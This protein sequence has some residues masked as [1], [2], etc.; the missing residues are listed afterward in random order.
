MF[1]IIYETTNLVNGKLYR[2]K[3][4]TKN[5]ND[6]Y[7]GS[8][9]YL[10]MSID[11]YGSENFSVSHLF[12][13]FTEED[14]YEVEAEFVDSEFVSRVDTYNMRI[15]GNGMPKGH[16]IPNRHLRWGQPHTEESKAKIGANQIGKDNHRT[17]VYYL[18]DPYGVV[19]EV[20]GYKRFCRDNNLSIGALC[21]VKNTGKC[22][23][24]TVGKGSHN[25]TETVINTVG[26]SM[27]LAII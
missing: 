12:F 4:T 17:K 9:K 3:H 11:K 2:G 23:Q 8:G 5:I 16:V 6:G 27:N 14:A 15:G 20:Y 22:V 10:K 21:R 19:H 24:L 13:A 18:T 26:W 25:N 7:M 1:H